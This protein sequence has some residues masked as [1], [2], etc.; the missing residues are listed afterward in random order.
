MQFIC[1]AEPLRVEN[2]RTMFTSAFQDQQQIALP[3]AHGEGNYYCDDA[4]LA[5]LRENHQIAF[6]YQNN[7]TAVYRT[8]L[9]LLTK[10]V[11][12]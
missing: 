3:I 1:G 12:Y 11:M 2:N 9:V 5:K 10:P 8:L 4:T 6:T 7:P